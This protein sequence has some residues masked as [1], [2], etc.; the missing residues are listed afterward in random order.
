MI[1]ESREFLLKIYF[2]NFSLFLILFLQI[3]QL[4]LILQFLP[5]YSSQ[6]EHLYQIVQ[7]ID[8][9]EHFLKKY[10]FCLNKKKKKKRYI[11]KKHWKSE[12]SPLIIVYIQNYLII[13]VD[14]FN[15]IYIYMYKAKISYIYIGNT[16]L[17]DLITGA[18]FSEVYPLVLSVSATISLAHN[19]Q[20][21]H[22]KCTAPRKHSRANQKVGRTESPG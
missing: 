7:K 15:P 17:N 13:Y 14:P 8:F 6:W 2:K 3:L 4:S 20:L 19:Y 10:I 18:C 9:K 12:A 21:G 5:F 11:V 1:L 22:Y 16:I